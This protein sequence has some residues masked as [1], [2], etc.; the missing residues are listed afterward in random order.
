MQRLLSRG[1]VQ[2]ASGL[3]LVLAA[4]SAA[5][6]LHL[7]TRR[8]G[9][10]LRSCLFPSDGHCGRSATQHVMTAFMQAQIDFSNTPEFAHFMAADPGSGPL[11]SMAFIS[12]HIRFGSLSGTRRASRSA[13]TQVLV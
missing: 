7:H 9:M 12:T 2:L 4:A 1:M 5:K 6:R 10:V 3:S 11:K 8:T 13:S